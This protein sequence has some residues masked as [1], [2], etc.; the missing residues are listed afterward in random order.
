MKLFC[1]GIALVMLLVAS[2]AWA[3]ARSTWVVF[4]PKGPGFKIELPMQPTMESHKMKTT[5]GP[6]RETWITFKG[7]N[8]LHGHI[9]VRDYEPK[10]IGKDPRGYLDESREF[11]E[12]GRP[13][14]SESR[15]SID[16]NPAQRFTM[17][18]P[19]NRIATV[20]EVVVGDRFV[21]VVCF[22]PKGKDN[23]AD[24]DRILKSFALTKS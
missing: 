10:T 6:A 3:Q 14:R 2:G 23:S 22:T 13:L 20:Q 7:E 5:Y 24:I 17:D 9:D 12:T 16:G 21:S 19:D 11:H 1:R 4:A 15:F 18:T 8:G